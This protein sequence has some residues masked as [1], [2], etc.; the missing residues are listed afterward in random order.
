MLETFPQL[1][2]AS[3]PATRTDAVGH[4][5]PCRHPI[6]S[7][8][9]QV[10]KE[11]H[12]S[13]S[14]VTAK[15]MVTAGIPKP[16]PPSTC[17]HQLLSSCHRHEATGKHKNC[18]SQTWPFSQYSTSMGVQAPSVWSLGKRWM[19]ETSAEQNREGIL[20][21]QNNK[22]PVTV[23]FLAEPRAGSSRNLNDR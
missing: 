6:P 8:L 22:P 4:P 3:G 15:R 1:R 17:R 9:T 11:R 10:Q 20:R 12:L 5:K 18:H 19:R 13:Q 2:E 21:K 23:W 7:L 14:C 16:V